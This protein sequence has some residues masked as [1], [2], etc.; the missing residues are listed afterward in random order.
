MTQFDRKYSLTIGQLKI[1]KLEIA[2]KV[3]KTPGKTP[4]TI[5]A[6]ILNLN[7]EHREELAQLEETSCRLEAGYQDNVG[8]IFTGDVRDIGSSRNEAEWVTT[9]ASG[10]GEKALA[11]ARVNESFAAG[12][13]LDVPIRKLAEKMKVGIGNAAQQALRGDFDGA[14]NQ[15]LH[16]M[17]LSGRASTEMDALCRSAGLEW[18]IQDGELQLLPIGDVLVGLAVRLAEDTGLIGSPTVGNDGV[19]TVQALLNP[20]IVPGRQLRIESEMVP[21]GFY[22]AE[23]CEY[24]GDTRG[25]DWLVEVEAKA[26]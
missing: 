19:V 21:Q 17:V 11:G 10:D 22:R 7:P 12:T 16:G 23:R 20:S 3:V 24:I 25:D 18:S 1:E 15:F 9:F 2:F 13:R 5:E 6:S 14:A 8:L 4:N 26:L